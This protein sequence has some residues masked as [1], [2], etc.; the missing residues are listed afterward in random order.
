MTVPI[1]LTS[2]A[3][4]QLLTKLILT[5]FSIYDVQA[6]CITAKGEKDLKR[7]RNNMLLVFPPHPHLRF[8]HMVRGCFGFGCAYPV[9]SYLGKTVKLA[10]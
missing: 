10:V 2:H 4:N 7:F 5:Y 6:M 9:D 1:T 3:L 8:S